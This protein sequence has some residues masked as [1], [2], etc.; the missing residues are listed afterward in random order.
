[1]CGFPPVHQVLGV[2]G[3]STIAGGFL[4][5]EQDVASS[6]QVL[7]QQMRR[8]RRA[9]SHDV[10]QKAAAGLERQILQLRSFQRAL[11][12]GLYWPMHGEISPLGIMQHPRAVHKHFYLP[13]LCGN[14]ARS[15]RFAPFT[16]KEHWRVNRFRIP[17]PQVP[18]N[19]W[20]SAADLDLLIMPLVAFD[21]EGFRLG[22][23]GGFYDRSLAHLSHRQRWRRPR[24]LGV[25]HAF[26][27][28]TRV[29]RE[30]WDIP[31]NIVCTEN[32]C[33]SFRASMERIPQP[34]L[35]PGTDHIIHIRQ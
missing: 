1:M 21:A 17:E 13:I 5:T 12:V 19:Q 34:S 32:A 7:R 16:G 6:K 2:A 10:L 26:Q 30:P 27:Q 8:Q 29:P 4:F 24:L 31:L 23:G 9:L 3:R 15:L 11:H 14:F 25:G 28:V 18:P 35:A 33:L 20:R 22:M